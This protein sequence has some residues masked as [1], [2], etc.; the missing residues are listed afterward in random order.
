MTDQLE[1]IPYSVVESLIHKLT[2]LASTDFGRVHGWIEK[3]DSLLYEIEIIK[4]ALLHADQNKEQDRAS[5]L[6]R[7]RL[8][9]ALHAADDFFDEVVTKISILERQDGGKVRG[10]FSCIDGVYFQFQ[11]A[12]EIEKLEKIFDD[13]LKMRMELNDNVPLFDTWKRATHS[14][15]PE[16]F[17]IGREDERRRIINLLLQPGDGSE[18]V[19]LIGVVGIGGIGK[20]AVAQMVYNDQ[21][22]KCCFDIRLWVY[23]SSDFDVKTVLKNILDS[24]I[25]RNSYHQESLESLQN[26]IQDLL[27]AKRYLLVLDDVWNESYEKWTQLKTYLMCGAPGSKILVTIRS[28]KVAEVMGVSSLFHLK[29]LSEEDSWSLFKHLAF[30]DND[31]RMIHSLEQVGKKIVKECRGVPLAIRTVGSMLF[32]KDT[33][34]EWITVLEGGF[35]NFGHDYSITSSLALSFQHLSPPQ[36]KQCLAYCSIYPIGREIEKNELIQLWMAHDYLECLNT[37][38]K[39]EDIGNEFVYT[40]LEISFFQD[41]KIDEYGN[42]VSFKMHDF[43]HDLAVAVVSNDFYLNN[44]RKVE[45]PLHMCFSL[46]SNAID[47]LGSIDGRRLR[48]FFLQQ[49]NDRGIARMTIELSII[50]RFKRLRAL[51]LSRSSLKMFP[52]LIGKLKHL[53]YLDLSWCVKLAR[54]PS[55]IGNLVNLQT[56]KLTGC[57]TLEFSTE[58]VTKLINLRH[59]EIHRCKAFKEMMPTGLG[60]LSSLQSLSS[61]YVVDDQKKKSGKLNELQNLNSLRGNLEINRLDQVKYVMLETQ[62][63][64]LKDKKLLESLDLNW[65]NQDNPKGNFQLL[66]NLCPHQNLKRLHVRWYPGDKFSNWLSSINHL[67]YISLFGFDNCKSLPPLEHLP[68]LKSLEISSMRVLEYIYLEEVFHT[69]ATFFPSLERLKFSGCKNFTGWK[70]NE[71]RVSVDNLSLPQF[72]CLSK[73][74]INKCPKLTDLPTFPNVK[75]MQLCESMMKPLKETLDMASSSSCSTPLS[76]LK[77]LKIEGKLPDISVLPSQWKQNLTSLE[78]LEIGDV[79]KPD[80]W[81]E[82]KFPSLQRVV[83]Y[84]CDLEALPNKMCDLLSLQH[85]KMMGCHKL[86]SLPKEMIKLNNLVTLEIWDCPLL[87]ER[88]QKETGVDWPQISHVQNIILKENL[89]R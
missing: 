61:F 25:E 27:Y 38:L 54:L 19:S 47:L 82:G 24:F 67:S 52:D 56:L 64:N 6:F 32:S 33:E 78:C 42:I 89:R 59:L 26:K 80:I 2:W 75:E 36:L 50:L 3:L 31:N 40:L 35:W 74:I 21:D 20:T 44:E 48:T 15:Q 58:V 60:K 72:R 4:A 7:I 8:K 17:L 53:R 65:E 22:V 71:G 18:N 1:F 73:L 84:G 39:M 86:A 12:H 23:V 46:E 45:T 16:S 10:L 63:V 5:K 28:T 43:M 37:E 88:C 34:S 29:S 69:A 55:T 57:E 68:Y 13:I 62:H 81:F 66:E 87:V 70:R 83:V 77:S 51:N 76:M 85:I 30:S 79:D 49:T 11:I 14:F 9:D 41:P